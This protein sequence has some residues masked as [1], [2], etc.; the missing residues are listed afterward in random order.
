MSGSSQRKNGTRKRDVCGAEN[1]SVEPININP[2]QIKIGSQYFNKERIEDAKLG[3]FKHLANF[4]KLMRSR[5]SQSSVA[6]AKANIQ[7]HKSAAP[8]SP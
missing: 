5:R 1:A 2:S 8:Y 6:I 4:A 3:T 7:R